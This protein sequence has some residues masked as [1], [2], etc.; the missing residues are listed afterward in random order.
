MDPNQIAAYIQ[1]G[2]VLVN[3]LGASIGQAKTLVSS[4]KAELHPEMTDAQLDEVL[5]GIES[6]ADR[7]KA[8]ADQDVKD[9]EGATGGDSSQSKP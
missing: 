1:L 9:V 8:L 7:R 3:V 4:I 2:G 5:A 6:D